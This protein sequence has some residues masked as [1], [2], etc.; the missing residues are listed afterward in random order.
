M[1]RS[2]KKTKY[3]GKIPNGFVALP[4]DMLNSRA[5]KE[6]K[7][8]SGKALPY[9]L[10]KVR[11]AYQDPQRFLSEFPFSY[12]EARKYGFANGTFYRIICDLMDKGF[13]DPADKGG[14]R[15]CCRSSSLFKL[16]NRWKDYGTED[17]QDVG[18]WKTFKGRRL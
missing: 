1:G 9:F 7:P 6:L 2:K 3:S 16:S 11:I 12:T 10:P 18:S 5:F 4:W 8:N 17:F 14:L 13:I 15:G